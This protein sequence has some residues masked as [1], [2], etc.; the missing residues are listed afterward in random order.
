MRTPP[1]HTV[2]RK[3]RHLSM[4]KLWCC[5]YHSLRFV[6]LAPIITKPCTWTKPHIA[7]ISS[8]LQLIN[9][10][11][12]SSVSPSV[13]RSQAC[14]PNPN[15]HGN[16]MDPT[17]NRFPGGTASRLFEPL[18]QPQ[19]ASAQSICLHIEISRCRVM[20]GFISRTAGGPSLHSSTAAAEP[21]TERTAKQGTRIL[22]GSYAVS[23]PELVG[24]C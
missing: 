5:E 12:P 1:R 22:G 14:I 7:L 15:S 8:Y 21:S 20:A 3:H 10:R 18:A 11:E 4:R 6:C 17:A 24:G 23:E 9:A 16:H 13:P 19:F 2:A